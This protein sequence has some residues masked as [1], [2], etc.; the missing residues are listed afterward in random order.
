MQKMHVVFQVA[1][2]DLASDF[3]EVRERLNKF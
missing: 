2:F 1:I 3:E